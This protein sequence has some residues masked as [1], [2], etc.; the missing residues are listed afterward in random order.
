MNLQVLS[1]VF[2]MAGHHFAGA[3]Q[4]LSASGTSAAATAAAADSMAT[5]VNGQL[6]EQGRG[7]VEVTHDSFA[8]KE[9]RQS[10]K[11]FLCGLAN[12]LVQILP[13]G[14]TLTKTI[15]QNLLQPC[16]PDGLRRELTD[17]ELE[18]HGFDSSKDRRFY[19]YD[20]ETRESAHDS[21]LNEDFIRLVIA[22]D[23]GTEALLLFLRVHGIDT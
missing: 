17:R 6:P 5:A 12:S 3:T 2:R 13:D 10:T 1:V 7:E 21:Y 20:T 15:P 14:F 23:E 18:A 9:Y 8:F 16:G 19:I 11:E 22:A 4:L